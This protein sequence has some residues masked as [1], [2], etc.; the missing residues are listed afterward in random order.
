MSSSNEKDNAAD[1]PVGRRRLPIDD[2]PTDEILKNNKSSI[3]ESNNDDDV[4]D[5]SSI[6]ESNN[7]DVVDVMAQPMLHAVIVDHSR[8]WDGS[9]QKAIARVPT[10][11]GGGD[12][13]TVSTTASVRFTRLF[14]DN[15][16]TKPVDNMVD[17]SFESEESTALK[18][19]KKKQRS[20]TVKPNNQ[21][22]NPPSIALANQQVSTKTTRRRKVAPSTTP[23]DN[24]TT[25]TNNTRAPTITSKRGTTT[26]RHLN[27]KRTSPPLQVKVGARI[28]V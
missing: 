18:P 27:A 4:V 12:D 2:S 21:P 10:P 13:S 22:K 17:C 6:V 23:P 24:L 25:P 19:P 9:G 3:V 7:D 8:V 26:A 20:N 5:N 28:T 1:R 11:M 15:I 16:A 14:V